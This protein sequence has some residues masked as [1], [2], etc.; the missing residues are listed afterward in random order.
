MSLIEAAVSIL[1]LGIIAFPLTCLY[2]S[3]SVHTAEARHETAALNFAA[4]VMEEIKAIP[5]NQTGFVREA[6]A[7]TVILENRSSGS[8][9]C[10]NNCHIAICGGTGA[11]QV[12]NITSYDGSMRCAVVDSDWLT[13]PDAA[14]VYI[15][16]GHC[17]G[18]YPFMVAAEAGRDNLKTIRVTVS[19]PT[20]NRKKEVSLT[21]EKLKR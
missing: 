17:P 9:G 21:A 10:Y 2:R 14:S 3:G 16:F 5:D 15:I 11:G 7:N 13:M 8:D 6:A 12:K 4:A 1:L 19:C 18:N 20:N